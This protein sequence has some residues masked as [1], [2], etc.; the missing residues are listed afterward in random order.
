MYGQILAPAANGAAIAFAGPPVPIAG[1]DGVNLRTLLTDATGAL[2]VVI[3]GGG[4]LGADIQKWGSVSVTAAGAPAD[5][6]T[7]AINAPRIITLESLWN[8]ATWDRAPGNT[9]GAFVQGNVASGVPVTSNPILN[10]GRAQSS[11][12][13]AVANG[14]A[15]AMWASLSGATIISGPSPTGAVPVANNNPVVIAGVSTVTGLVQN[16]P[17]LTTAAAS[18]AAGNPTGPLVTTADMMVWNNPGNTWERARTSGAGNNISGTG[19]AAAANYGQYQNNAGVFTITSGNQALFQLDP[20][21]NLRTA[22][23]RPAT[24]DILDAS[25]SHT[26]TTAATTIITVPA[27]RTWVG[28][29]FIS[30]A[31]GIAAASTVA[32]QARGVIST[33]GTGPFPA[34]GNYFPVEAKCGANAATGTVGMSGNNSGAVIMT[35][36]APAGNSVTVQGTTTI[37]GTAGAVDYSAIGNLQ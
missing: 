1:S 35:V 30:C 10:G 13:A 32:G 20:A 37:T 7:N 11:L 17:A 9:S 19:I 26:A 15:V 31:V 22:P 21:G 16:Q 8:G 2:Q 12:P 28:Y 5:A 29:I 36:T 18:D 25:L 14:Q 23:Q 4:T 27:G 3:A 34:A 6:L 24:G 33:A